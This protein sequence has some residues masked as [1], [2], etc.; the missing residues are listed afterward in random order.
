[1]DA[2]PTEDVADP[3]DNPEMAVMRAQD[4]RM[5]GRLLERLPVELREALTLREIYEMSYREIADIVAAPI[6]TVMSR[7]W[8]A[9]KL[10]A[11]AARAEG[12]L[13]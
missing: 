13:R 4:R 10:I 1:M 11:E 8:R 5:I 9:R 12:Y 7:L 2:G 3:A 6:G